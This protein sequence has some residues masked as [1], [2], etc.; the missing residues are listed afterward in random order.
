MN[1]QDIAKDKMGYFKKGNFLYYISNDR[2]NLYIDLKIE[3]SGVQYKI[4]QDGMAVWINVDGK[5]R[6]EAGIRF[7]LGARLAKGPGMQGNESPLAIAKVIQV[8]G[9]SGAE[10]EMIPAD[11]PDNFS[12][13]VKY[14]SQGILFYYLR[15][16]LT[17]IPFLKNKTG[18]GLE[19]FTLG[20]E[21]GGIPVVG[22]RPTG[23]MPQ[24]PADM[25]PS[26][27]S[28]GGGR[29]GSRGG[30]GGRSGGGMPGGNM[31]GGSGNF[32]PP[33]A[34]TSTILWLKNISL[35]AQD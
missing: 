6:K 28:G 21:Y 11:N 17:R 5:S 23:Q 26:G 35:A 2:D 34:E 9:L 31:G 15:M 22:S 29:G 32:Q 8:I 19:P 33:A 13:S 18:D 7:P 1:I 4:L 12:G 20:I 16:P 14:D 10:R 25:P 30:G 3:D 24:M 27:R